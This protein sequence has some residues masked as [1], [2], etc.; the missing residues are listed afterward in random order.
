MLCAGLPTPYRPRR[1]A[2]NAGSVTV[3]VE[4]R[5]KLLID[6]RHPRV[7]VQAALLHPVQDEEAL[8]PSLLKPSSSPLKIVGWAPCPSAFKAEDGLGGHITFFNRLLYD[9]GPSTTASRFGDAHFAAAVSH[10]ANS[11]RPA[12]SFA[13]VG[14]AKTRT[15]FT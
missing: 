12:S 9:C 8:A 1:P 4:P 3:V 14:S 7:E 11:L 5:G 6:L 13:N 15:R 2:P 10:S